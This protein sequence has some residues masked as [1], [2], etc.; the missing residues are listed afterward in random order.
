MI[1]VEPQ[2]LHLQ[3]GQKVLDLGCG[4]GRHAIHLWLS[5]AVDVVGVD[6]NFTDVRTACDRA[7]PFA[8]NATPPGRLLLGVADGQQLPFADNTFDVVICSEV[9][10]HIEDYRGLL[11]EI[12]RVLKPA[13]VFSASVPAFFPEWICWR[14]SDE[15]HQVEGGHI[16]IFRERVL[17][18]SIEDL[19]HRLYFRHKAHAL[20]SP[21][22]WLKC[23][24]WH[25]PESRVL[26]AYHKL[27]VW[28][29]MQKP[30]L[31][32]VLERLLNPL[33]GKSIVLY[34][35]KPRDCETAG[36][37]YPRAGASV[38]VEGRS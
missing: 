18:G 4:E 31:T 32:R 34:F 7:R 30:R 14:L 5:D 23:L 38:A 6:L 27:L 37:E 35:V 13:G 3:P 16:R 17:R 36:A 33:L 26:A 24:L 15:Y 29:M 19:G 25:K 9:L 10:E 1:T 21:Y 2:R 8:E 22:W 12:D 11:A 28:D 20:H